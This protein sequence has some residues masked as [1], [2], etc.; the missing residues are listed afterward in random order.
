MRVAVECKSPLLQKSLELFLGKHLSSLK[1][2]DILIRDVRCLDDKRCFY[3][4]GSKD[5][6]LVK[7]FSK[8]QLF[9]ALENRYK[10]LN[11]ANLYSSDFIDE[12]QPDFDILQRRIE[13]LTKEYQENILKAVRAFYEK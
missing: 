10:S 11:K 12:E 9:L 6:D 7:P 1:N 2:C 13:S 4:S 8:S 5:S 3:I